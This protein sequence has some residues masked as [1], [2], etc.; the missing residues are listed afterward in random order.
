MSANKFVLKGSGVEVD[1]TFQSDHLLY[2]NSPLLA[3]GTV[4]DVVVTTPDGT[5][6]TLVKGWV[7]DFLDV[8]ENH[9]FHTFITQLISNAITVGIG[10][11]LYGVDQPTLRQQMAAL[12]LKARHGLCYVP[13]PCTGQ[14]D[15][16]PCPSTFAAWIEAFANE[17]ITGGC[18]GNNFCPANPVRRDQMAVFLLKAEHGPGYVPPDCTGLYSDVPCPSFFANWIEQLG[19][20]GITGGCG[21]GHYCPTSSIT[22]GQMA[23]FLVKTFKLP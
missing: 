23:V 16:V 5:T 9:Q 7:S 13:P 11:G 15:D 18:G 1:Y 12:V 10:G 19:T 2:S 14:F 21:S 3:A 6:G 4:N 20:E 8:P 22:R 17:G